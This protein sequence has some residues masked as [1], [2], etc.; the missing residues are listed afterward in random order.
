ES[1]DCR[2]RYELSGFT[3]AHAARPLA[4]SSP[5]KLAP[6]A[7]HILVVVA[8]RRDGQKRRALASHLPEQRIVRNACPAVWPS[9]HPSEFF[10]PQLQTSGLET[11]EQ[12]Q[13][14]RTLQHGI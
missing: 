2:R 6:S 1:P 3:G 7:G 12:G 5:K 14:G 8:F 13:L 9:R 11:G 4:H 10:V